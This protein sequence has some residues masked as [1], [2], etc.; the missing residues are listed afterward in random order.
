MLESLHITQDRNQPQ[1]LTGLINNLYASSSR[2]AHSS[3]LVDKNKEKVREFEFDGN[4]S[5]HEND[6]EEDFQDKDDG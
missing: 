4:S 2:R 1:N 3:T 6:S 5:G